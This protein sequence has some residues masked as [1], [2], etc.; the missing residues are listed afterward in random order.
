MLPTVQSPRALPGGVAGR[1]GGVAGCEGGAA[2]AA[3]AA[4]LATAV[5]DAW[6]LRRAR[7]RSPQGG[8]VVG[9]SA[10][11][12]R[13]LRAEDVAVPLESLPLDVEDDIYAD[14]IECTSNAVREHTLLRPLLLC[15]LVRLM[16]EVVEEVEG[17]SHLEDT[18]DAT[19]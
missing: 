7:W 9:V 10:G 2:A 12:P 14:L 8:E 19:W 16:A 6:S 4:P 17:R 18:E 15:D 11:D 5:A 1:A 3:T 13:R